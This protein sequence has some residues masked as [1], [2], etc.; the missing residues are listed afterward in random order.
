MSLS[1]TLG[2]RFA[3]LGGSYARLPFRR[4]D[5]AFQRGAHIRSRL[6][7]E[8]S[9]GSG[10]SHFLAR[11]S[12]RPPTTDG[13]SVLGILHP[14]LRCADG[15]AMFW[16]LRFAKEAKPHRFALGLCHLAAVASHVRSVSRVVWVVSFVDAELFFR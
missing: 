16:R 5:T 6:L 3:A 8:D 9:S 7:R 12:G 14:S 13:V 11:L 15:R 4:E 1:S 10:Y 2:P